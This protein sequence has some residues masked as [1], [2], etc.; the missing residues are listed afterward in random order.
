MSFA[1]FTPKSVGGEE[2][3]EGISQADTLVSQCL[4]RSRW[5]KSAVSSAL[6]KMMLQAGKESPALE[7]ALLRLRDAHEPPLM[8]S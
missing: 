8:T 4:G 2:G 5:N 7:E 3:G 1:Y 6:G